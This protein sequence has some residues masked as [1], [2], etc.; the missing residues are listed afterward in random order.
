MI[1]INIKPLSVNK[2]WQGR[3]FKT[4][5]YKDYE[6]EVLYLLP[7][8]YRIPRGKLQLDLVFGLSNRRSDIDNPIKNFTD[9]LQKK[10]GFDDKSIYKMIVEKRDT[11][12][13]E[14]YVEFEINILKQL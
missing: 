13:G 7:K 12:K 14:E 2:A 10:Y 8:D 11:K 1:K 9:I 5:E 6:E 3:R 4:Q